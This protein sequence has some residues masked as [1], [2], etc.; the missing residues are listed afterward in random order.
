MDV[1][2]DRAEEASC[3]VS[4]VR[5]SPIEGDPSVGTSMTND[6]LI[7]DGLT[8]GE[9][10]AC[11]HLSLGG[12]IRSGI[13]HTCDGGGLGYNGWDESTFTKTHNPLTRLSECSLA[14]VPLAGTSQEGD[15]L[16]FQEEGTATCT[17]GYETKSSEIAPTTRTRHLDGYTSVDGGWQ[18]PK[19]VTTT[20]LQC[21]DSTIA[22]NE[23]ARRARSAK[24]DGRRDASW[25][26]LLAPSLPLV[27]IRERLRVLARTTALLSWLGTFSFA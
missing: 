4:D 14:F 26:A 15:G 17:D 18:F 25:V 24:L 7:D 10:K 12:P 21:S 13:A 22:Q 23:K 3:V 6:S 1:C 11:A 20:V 2:I 27:T 19:W 16:A 8:T 5:G 9:P